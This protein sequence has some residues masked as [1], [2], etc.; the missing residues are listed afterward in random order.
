MKSDN[1]FELVATIT[2]PSGTPYEGGTFELEI[3]MPENY[4][5][6]PPNVSKS[7]CLLI[8][9]AKPLNKPTTHKTKHHTN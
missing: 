9:I 4:P 7:I 3:K 8:S 1:L 2:G 5:F 6:S